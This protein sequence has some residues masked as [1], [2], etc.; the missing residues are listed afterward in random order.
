MK[1]SGFAW[2]GE[3]PEH[4]VEKRAKYFYR[5]TDERS[6]VDNE[7]LCLSRIRPMQ[8]LA[9]KALRCVGEEQV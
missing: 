7:Q 4:W 8:I 3:L 6:E 1:S 5:E 2:L 9:R